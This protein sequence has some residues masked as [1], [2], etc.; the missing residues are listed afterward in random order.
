MDTDDVTIADRIAMAVGGGLILLGV[1]ALGFVNTILG[2]PH[3]PVVEEGTVVASPVVSPELRAAL[4]ALGLLVWFV[5]GAY[6]LATPAGRRD[7]PSPT[8]A[9]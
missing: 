3:Q 6:K 1:V 7:G 2:A 9:D 8:P 5:Y 4:V